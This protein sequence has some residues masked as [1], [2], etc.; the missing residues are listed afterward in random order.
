MLK[1]RLKNEKGLTLV[2]LLAVVVIL[3]IVAAIAIPAIGNM[4]ENS[5]YNAAK[6]DAINIINAANLYFTEVGSSNDD[7]VSVKDLLDGNYL[8]T[9]GVFEKYENK[10]H[11]ANYK[12]KRASGGNTLYA[13]D[14][15]F[16]GEKKVTF[17]DATIQDINNDNEKGSEIDKDG[18]EIPGTSNSGS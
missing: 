11:I 17:N 16:S 6:S 5:R 4:L 14:V 2:E 1:K 7:E 3:G 8:D 18:H 10:D 12:V 13:S 15:I 9:A